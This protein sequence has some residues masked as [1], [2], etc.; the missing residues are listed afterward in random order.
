MSGAE[1]L[2][3]LESV[4]RS[5]RDNPPAG[6]YSAGLLSDPERASRKIMEEAFE[7]CWELGRTRVDPDRLASESA[8]LIF[9]LFTGLVGAGV[10]VDDVWKELAARRSGDTS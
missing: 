10:P 6:S 5:R 3:E 8:D 7:V 2:G 9:H 1:I 4:L